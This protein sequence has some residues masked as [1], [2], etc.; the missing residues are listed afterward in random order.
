MIAKLPHIKL[1]NSSEVIVIKLIFELIY[2]QVSDKERVQSERYYIR[3]Y[4]RQWRQSK[5]DGELIEFN[6][7]H[8]QYE[9]LIQSTLIIIINV[10]V[11]TTVHGEPDDGDIENGTKG[12]ALKNSLLSKY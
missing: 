5:R 10:L 9:K 11:Y 2:N 7:S 12:S 6:I 8:P 3:R 4:L 1:L